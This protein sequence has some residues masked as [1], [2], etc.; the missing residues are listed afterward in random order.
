MSRRLRVVLADADAATRAAVRAALDGGT[1]EVVAEAADAAGTL[2]AVLEHRPDVCLLDI[3]LPGNGLATIAS[4]TRWAPETA[5][6]VLT[7][8]PEDDDVLAALRAGAA[9]CLL[10]SM[11]L[12]R[13]A[14][15]LHGVHAGESVI[16]R[17]LMTGVLARIR[18]APA[19][20]TTPQAGTATARLTEREAEVL[21]LLAAGLSTEEIAQRLF[22]AKVTVRTHIRAVLKKL[23][24]P[25]RQAAVRLT[26]GEREPSA[27]AEC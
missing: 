22:V 26:R 5:T 14:P 1:C 21:E 17:T 25:D 9:G 23:R 10:E 18:T 4:V 12:R 2:A 3:H 19:N 11:D 24:V 13:L 27:G 7:A 15:A 16:P 20:R 6:V 8:S